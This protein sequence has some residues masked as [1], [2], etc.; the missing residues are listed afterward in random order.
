MRWADVASDAV[1]QA[2]SGVSAP[3]IPRRGVNR[4]VFGFNSEPE[5]NAGVRF[6]PPRGVRAW[7]SVMLLRPALGR[8]AWGVAWPD[9]CRS[10]TGGSGIRHA[11]SRSPMCR[12][13]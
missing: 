4:G 13:E 6:A 1:G 3:G 12:V 2:R 11:C 8:F 9:R 5:G 10:E 7:D